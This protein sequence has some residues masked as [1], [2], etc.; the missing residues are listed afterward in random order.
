MSFEFIALISVQNIPFVTLTERLQKEGICIAESATD[1]TIRFRWTE[2]QRRE[3]WPEDVELSTIETG[4]L[5]TIHSGTQQQRSRMVE[6]VSRIVS[7]LMGKSVT[8]NEV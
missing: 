6:T 1:D 8:F 2:T 5:L 3:K 7:E 4:L